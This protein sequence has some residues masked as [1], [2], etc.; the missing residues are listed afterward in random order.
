VSYAATWY[1]GIGR[2]VETANYGA[3]GNSCSRPDAPP[4]VTDADV[5]ATAYQYVYAD[6]NGDGQTEY[7]VE[8]ITSTPDGTATRTDWTVYDPAGRMIETI[9]NYGAD[10]LDANG[11]PVAGDTDE[12]V[13]VTYGYDSAGRL[14]TQT[15]YDAT[16]TALTPEITKYLYASTYGGTTAAIN[17]SWQTAVVYPDSADTTTQNAN[18]DWTITTDLG[19][20]TS[21][22]YDWLG[23]TTSM[24]DQR[25]VAHTYLYDSAGRLR[26]DTVD[27]TGEHSGQNVD[28]AVLAIV[29]T[30]D[31]LGRVAFT[32]SYSSAD[33]QDWDSAHTVNQV[34]DLYDGWGN[35]TDQ[36]QAHDGQVDTQSTPD[37]QYL[38]DDGAGTGG[39]AQYVRLSQVKYPGGDRTIDYNYNTGAQGAVDDIM[40]RLSSMSDSVGPLSSY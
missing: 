36:Y 2:Q 34:E 11:L 9:Q 3:A 10:A 29:T 32:T 20:H 12:D 5:L 26:A 15:A 17:A 14:A 38:Y 6:V 33:S 21:T 22:T 18:G 40:S 13:T 27:L 24:T 4:V 7:I 16:P 35:L 8:T 25:G 28:N 39:V 1:D 31:D 23:R 37:V 30:Y 19:G